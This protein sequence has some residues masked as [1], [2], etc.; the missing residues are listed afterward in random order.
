MKKSVEQ[1]FSGLTYAEGTNL[2]SEWGARINFCDFLVYCQKPKPKISNF[3]YPEKL[4][5]PV[6]IADVDCNF[7]TQK[8]LIRKLSFALFLSTF[9]D[10]SFKIT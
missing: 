10:I 5:S 1:L 3:H 6:K 7:M 4:L 8:I 2:K 9:K